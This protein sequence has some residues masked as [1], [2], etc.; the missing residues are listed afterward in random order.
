MTTI[1]PGRLAGLAG[2]CHP[3]PTVAVTGLVTA[4]AAIAGRDPA[5]CAL[6]AAAVLA[7]Q[8][9]VGWSN[10]AVDATRDAAAG[11]TS[12]PVVS[13]AVRAGALWR[14]ALIALACCVPLSLAS[15]VEAGAA[16]LVGVAAA[17]AYN[18]GLKATALS[19]LP[20]AVGFGSLPAFVALGLPGAPWPAWW[21]V[22]AAALLGVGA[23]LANVL[24]DIE[25]DLAAGVRGGPQRLGAG[26]VRVMLPLPLLAATVVLVVGADLGA[27][28]WAGLG[29][30]LLPAGAGI[31][32]ARRSPR[33]PF[34]AAVAV[35]AVD[36][37]LLLAA[38]GDI[39]R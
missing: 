21:A 31:A 20:Y 30:A 34:W 7:G 4:L 35:T 19:W 10:D 12:K 36:V 29:A 37:A 24:P 17:W 14:A 25:D 28:G 2:A 8:L 9:S 33:A 39:T 26:R 5:G 13:G 32:A 23:H 27:A 3:G 16:H 38:G 15:G 11:R 18:L 6:V 22:S 1:A